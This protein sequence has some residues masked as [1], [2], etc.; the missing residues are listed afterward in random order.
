MKEGSEQRMKGQSVRKRFGNPCVL[1]WHVVGS[2]N[3][4]GKKTHGKRKPVQLQYPEC[5][6]EGS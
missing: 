3:L 6:M 5:F 2:L 1:A 4:A